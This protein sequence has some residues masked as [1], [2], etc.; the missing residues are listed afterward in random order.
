MELSELR[1]R[2]DM[3]DGSL[4]ELFLR[5]MELSAEIARCKSAAALPVRDE[6]REREKL[7]QVRAL[8]PEPLREYTAELYEL[9][10]DLSRRYQRRLSDGGEATE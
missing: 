2:I 4:T 7:A 1:D 8:S 3:I 6:A 10:I 9:L 5:R